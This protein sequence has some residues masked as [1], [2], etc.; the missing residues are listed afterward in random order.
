[1]HSHSLIPFVTLSLHYLVTILHYMIKALHYMITWSHHCTTWSEHCT[2]GGHLPPRS[3]TAVK[4]PA[5]AHIMVCIYIDTH[6]P[7]TSRWILK[8]KF[9]YSKYCSAIW[10]IPYTLE[11]QTMISDPGFN[12]F[13]V[14]HINVS[15]FT[16]TQQKLCLDRI[17]QMH[18][19]VSILAK[20][21]I[22]WRKRGLSILTWWTIAGPLS[23][24]CSTMW[25]WKLNG[26]KFQS[27]TCCKS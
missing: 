16:L 19:G 17:P 2:R 9:K 7:L 1:M 20:S 8:S 22:H 13:D 11:N 15:R 3:C 26:N 4:L 23:A 27:V 21:N 12:Y 24:V 18:R 5:V 25:C 10:G 6:C 14:L